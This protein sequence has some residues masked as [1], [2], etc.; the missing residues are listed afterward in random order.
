M[1]RGSVSVRVDDATRSPRNTAVAA[2][3][4]RFSTTPPQSPPRTGGWSPQT[5][6]RT[7]QTSPMTDILNLVASDVGATYA[8]SSTDA[9]ASSSAAANVSAIIRAAAE[10]AVL[11]SA[12]RDGRRPKGRF[13]SSQA[14]SAASSPHRGRNSAASSPARRE[15]GNGASFPGYSLTHSPKGKGHTVISTKRTPPPLSPPGRSAKNNTSSFDEAFAALTES[16]PTPEANTNQ[17]D[18]ETQSPE[19]SSATTTASAREETARAMDALR[20]LRVA[21]QRERSAHGTEVAALR[22]AVADTAKS[23]RDEAT[24]D[25]R[26]AAAADAR[27]AREEGRAEAAAAADKTR[28]VEIARAVDFALANARVEGA[29]HAEAAVR[30]AVSA[31]VAAREMELGEAARRAAMDVGGAADRRVADAES[32]ALATVAA[33]RADAAALVEA[34]AA[35]ASAKVRE[36]EHRAAD[37]IRESEEKSERAAQALRRDEVRVADVAET[38]HSAVADADA[39]VFEAEH[40]FKEQQRRAD[41][42]EQQLLR[43]ATEAVRAVDEADAKRVEVT[44]KLNASLLLKTNALEQYEI[45]EAE[46]RT[47]AREEL[48]Q[49]R[50]EARVSE[51]AVTHAAERRVKHFRAQCAARTKRETEKT[52]RD[53]EKALAAAEAA[54]EEHV[55]IE[56]AKT[57]AAKME[58]A[59]HVKRTKGQGSAHERR[60][61]AVEQ[62]AKQAVFAAKK[63]AEGTIAEAVSEKNRWI[64]RARGAEAKADASD[65]EKRDLEK[66]LCLQIKILSDNAAE[67][68]SA[69][70]QLQ[71]ETHAALE[72]SAA[73]RKT[74]D[75]RTRNAL[76][77]TSRVAKSAR[78]F[79]VKLTCMRAWQHLATPKVEAPVEHGNETRMKKTTRKSEHQKG[80]DYD[81]DR[82]KRGNHLALRSATGAS[83]SSSSESSDSDSDS[84]SSHGSTRG[85]EKPSGRGGGRLPSA[86]AGPVT[87]STAQ[88]ALEWKDRLREDFGP[89]KRHATLWK[90]PNLKPNPNP[91]PKERRARR[92]FQNNGDPYVAHE[93]PGKDKPGSDTPTSTSMEMEI[94]AR[95]REGV[96]AGS[97]RR[98]LELERAL[99]LARNET[100]RDETNRAATAVST[101][102]AEVVPR[103]AIV[104][105]VDVPM[106]QS[107]E[108]E[109]KPEP[110]PVT[111][112]AYGQTV[113]TESARKHPWAVARDA[114]RENARSAVCEQPTAVPEPWPEP[115]PEP[116]PVPEPTPAPAPAPAPDPTPAP[117]VD[118]KLQAQLLL[119]A[120][121]QAQTRSLLEAQVQALLRAQAQALA[122]IQSGAQLT[123]SNA[124][125]VY[126][127]SAQPWPAFQPS[128]LFPPRS[129][130]SPGGAFHPPAPSASSQQRPVSASGY[131]PRPLSASC[132]FPPRPPGE[133]AFAR[134][135]DDRSAMSRVQSS[136]SEDQFGQFRAGYA[137]YA[138]SAPSSPNE[139]ARHANAWAS[140]SASRAE[141]Y[142]NNPVLLRSMGGNASN[143]FTPITSRQSA[144]F[145]AVCA[146]LESAR[147]L[148]GGATELSAPRSVAPSRH[149]APSPQSGFR[150][151]GVTHTMG[152]GMEAN[153]G[154]PSELDRI[155]RRVLDPRAA[156]SSLGASALK[157]GGRF[158]KETGKTGGAIPGGVSGSAPRR[159]L[160]WADGDDAY[161]ANLER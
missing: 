107:G 4:A 120:R 62:T 115:K 76:E 154:T 28:L 146:T 29:Q 74:S 103:A 143:A 73:A 95:R 114:V 59:D 72:A 37:A 101:P 111:T 17:N 124:Q 93:E 35:E 110:K 79:R 126:Q 158:G 85:K 45:K 112:A 116:V 9:N 129:T 68:E 77:A 16:L 41:D 83:T 34:A 51:Q 157:S 5:Q 91:Q 63:E 31:A 87:P 33:A 108:P 100:R 70:V 2:A 92:R 161:D 36:A 80:R 133:L 150:N 20:A 99:D 122:Q 21:S 13:A 86:P 98:V 121:A 24:R 106:A 55:V 52:E 18:R 117:Q 11:A 25:A 58:L 3:S 105:D 23:A 151:P 153:R 15:D 14:S 54:Y 43:C 148:L 88:V 66:K 6:P 138:A 142:G 160:R 10:A 141:L 30:A 26:A 119:E 139:P 140:Q 102:T 90:D 94:A 39:R 1:A 149:S 136:Q 131:F 19:A 57:H 69:F 40:R 22:A 67:K 104:K 134:E 132:G 65:R 50:E 32:G 97:E 38:L 81:S 8:P 147:K 159:A 89:T 64:K 125:P 61:A 12:G 84:D 48:E 144:A 46:Q 27:R 42:L 137:G 47:R 113:T 56:R 118:S 156:A 78:G 7:Q 130:P 145:G 71:K 123:Q 60:I 49:L 82:G 127:S 44:R 135:P 152:Y 128:P 96:L 155:P 75:K 109:P 53:F